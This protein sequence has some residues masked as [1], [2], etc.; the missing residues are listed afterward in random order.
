MRRYLPRVIG[1]VLPLAVALGVGGC[2]LEPPRERYVPKT[3]HTLMTKQDRNLFHYI[4]PY[5]HF[6][7][8]ERPQSFVGP[9]EAIGFD[10]TQMLIY[11]GGDEG[12][13]FVYDPNVY[14]EGDEVSFSMEVGESFYPLDSERRFRFYDLV[15]DEIH[16]RGA[17]EPIEFKRAVVV[18]DELVEEEL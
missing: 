3:S 4:D 16:L 7:D 12:R 5:H 1:L 2:P 17:E 15:E 6:P 18:E 10:D 13:S 11:V 8:G 9:I 14:R